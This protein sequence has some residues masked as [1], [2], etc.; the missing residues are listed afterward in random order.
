MKRS[1]RRLKKAQQREYTSMDCSW[2]ER[3]GTEKSRASQINSL[4][5]STIECPSSGS[6]LYR[7]TF[8]ILRSTVAP[9]TRPL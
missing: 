6:S 7:I 5:N 4:A 1:P 2:M 3:D 9:F 8:Q